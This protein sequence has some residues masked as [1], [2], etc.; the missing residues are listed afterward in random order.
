MNDY[1][2]VKKHINTKVGGGV[3]LLCQESR[4][5]IERKDLGVFND[6][7]ESI[8]IEIDNSQFDMRKIS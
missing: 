1:I 2:L 7:I 3:A 5:F 8:I 6:H 4:E